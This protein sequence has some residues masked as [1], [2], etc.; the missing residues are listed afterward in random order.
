VAS[1]C[2]SPPVY[3]RTGGARPS[4]LHFQRSG[5]RTWV[6]RVSQTQL[7]RPK[8]PRAAPHAA[9]QEITGA[10][11]LSERLSKT[12]VSEPLRTVCA[13]VDT[14]IGGQAKWSDLIRERCAWGQ[15][16]EGTW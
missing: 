8:L 15:G 11:A 4:W 10:V 5:G 2:L 12:P 3:E 16:A 9:L 1:G 14:R 6:F 7:C 13:E